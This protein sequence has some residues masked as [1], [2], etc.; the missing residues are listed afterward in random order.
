MS[1]RE[2]ARERTQFLMTHLQISAIPMRQ[3]SV[4]TNRK[5]RRMDICND[6]KWPRE[7]ISQGTV[8]GRGKG[9]HKRTTS[10]SKGVHVWTSTVIMGR[11]GG[12]RE[13][14]MAEE[15][16]RCQPWCPYD[17]DDS[18]DTGNIMYVSIATHGVLYI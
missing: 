16:R 1:Y 6:N 7:R 5:L 2:V 10:I 15:Y 8:P 13:P 17:P 18:G 9:R 12:D 4:P 3:L 14:K 11:S